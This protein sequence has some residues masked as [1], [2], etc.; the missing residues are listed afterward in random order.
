[1]DGG[2][3]VGIRSA[4]AN[5]A[6]HALTDLDIGHA[7]RRRLFFEDDAVISAKTA[8]ALRNG[9]T[10]LLC[11]GEIE[12]APAAVAALEVTQQIDAALA[13]SAAATCGLLPTNA[14]L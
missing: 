5:V 7:E 1:M 8:A 14:S 3:N 4:A 11:V 12:Q 13:A 10:P 6:A 9:I 2:N